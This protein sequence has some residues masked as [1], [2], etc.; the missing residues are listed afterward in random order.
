MMPNSSSA[1]SPSCILATRSLTR[2][3]PTPR[4]FYSKEICR[5]YVKFNF[6]SMESKAHRCY[7]GMLKKTTINFIFMIFN[8]FLW[9]GTR[10]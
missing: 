2:T 4:R 5:S 6:F 7:T 9:L 8:E 1:N 10:I 3:A